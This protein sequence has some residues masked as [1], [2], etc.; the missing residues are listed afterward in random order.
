MNKSYFYIE[1]AFHHEGDLDYLKKLINAAKELKVDGV[2]FQVLTQVDDFVSVY[3]SAFEQLKSYCFSLTQWDEVFKYTL[4]LGLDIILMPLNVEALKLADKYPIRYLDIHSVSFNDVKLLSAINEYDNDIILAIGGRDKTEI[5]NKITFFMHKIK[6]LMVGF[7]SFP[8]KL[9][10][11]NLGKIEWVKKDF[12]N[13]KIGYADHSSFDDEYAVLSN[14]Y[15][16]LLGAT[17]FEKHFTLDEGLERVDFNS[18]IG[19]KKMQTILD[20]INFIDKSI[21][22]EQENAYVFNEK[23][24]VYRERQLVCVASRDIEEN[25]ILKLID[26]D[27]KM[28]TNGANFISDC[29]ELIGKKTLTTLKKDVPFK[30]SDLI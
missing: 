30:K 18:A 17:I 24:V 15:A 20:R 29:T 27:F 21:L 28:I 19:V 8:S 13:F 25:T 7:Q 2:K 23:E 9:E 10:D 22:I 26:I 14:E 16:R 3:H 5:E 4:S 11:V 12:P 1:T 6:V